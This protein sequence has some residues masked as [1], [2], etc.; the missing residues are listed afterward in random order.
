MYTGC[1]GLFK[2]TLFFCIC[3]HYVPQ[4]PHTYYI[5]TN[6]NTLGYYARSFLLPY[7]KINIIEWN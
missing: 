6:A 3:P 5:P 1:I 4:T 7:H 2:N